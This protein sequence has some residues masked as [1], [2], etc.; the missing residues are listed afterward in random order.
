[1]FQEV[2]EV[3]VQ[4]TC[5]QAGQRRQEDSQ[6]GRAWPPL[7]LS[8]EWPNKL[9]LCTVSQGVNMSTQLVARS[10]LTLAVI[11]NIASALWSGKDKQDTSDVVCLLQSH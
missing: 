4:T 5:S 10:K 9:R 1:M 7:D 11:S 2:N 8:L 6:R 3:T